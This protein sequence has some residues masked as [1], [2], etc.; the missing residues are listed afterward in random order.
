MCLRHW[1]D[2][3]SVSPLIPATVRMQP[4][5]AWDWQSQG[6]LTPRLIA[7]CFIHTCYV[8][9]LPAGDFG[10]AKRLTTT[11]D[12]ASSFVGTPCC[13]APEMCQDIPYS[14]KADVWVSL[15]SH[16]RVCILLCLFDSITLHCS[17]WCFTQ[18]KWLSVSSE[19]MTR[20][21]HWQ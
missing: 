20:I 10:I 1:P 15:R 9:W 11:M 18:L 4:E 2:W 5:L 19:Q 13:L 17:I 3:Y 21:R 8:V 12:N 6:W 7:R 14:S 16:Q